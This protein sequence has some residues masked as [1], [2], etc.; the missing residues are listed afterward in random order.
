MPHTQ[1]HRV[2]IQTYII[3]NTMYS[4]SMLRTF[5]RGVRGRMAN[6]RFSTGKDSGTL[7]S[8]NKG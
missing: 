6:Q 1:D 8:S 4:Y 2:I 3:N 7:F 5:L